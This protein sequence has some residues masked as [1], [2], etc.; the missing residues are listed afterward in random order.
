M[1]DR[2]VVLQEWA[3]ETGEATGAPAVV[4][5]WRD[6]QEELDAATADQDPAAAFR[7][8]SVTKTFVAVAVLRLVE[9]GRLALTSPLTAVLGEESV[10]LLRDGRLRVEDLTVDHLLTHTSGLVDHAT[11]PAYVADV[12]G[13]PGR[14]WTRHEQVKRA[15]ELGPLA[16]PATLVSYSDTGYVLL[17]EV[18][19]RATGRALGPAVRELVGLDRLGLAATWWEVDEEPPVVPRVHQ[20]VHGVPLSDVSPTVDLF[21]GGGLVSTTADLARFFAALVAGEVLGA[22]GTRLLLTVT[23]LPGERP[24][25][26]R[27][28]FREEVGGSEW[29]SHGGFWGVYAG[30]AASG[31]AVGLC[32]S[33]HD[34]MA[35]LDRPRAVADLARRMD[36]AAG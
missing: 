22:S 21:G 6:E 15:A 23:D 24:G 7:I 5:S 17:G 14:A 30:A 29:W 9:E 27:G 11:D 28:I 20:T 32:L 8:A 1:T 4:V 36:R 12:L 35:Q 25:L 13:E 26:A 34:A 31:Q 33:E 2:A 19:E 18:L 10:Q 3:A 16:P